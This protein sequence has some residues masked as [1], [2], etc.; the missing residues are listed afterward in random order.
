M[1]FEGTDAKMR[2]GVRIFFS[3]GAFVYDV[4]FLRRLRAYLNNVIKDKTK[5]ITEPMH[6]EVKGKSRRTGRVVSVSA[7]SKAQVSRRTEDPD[8]V[9]CGACENTKQYR[10]AI[11]ERFDPGVVHLDDPHPHRRTACNCWAYFS[12]DDLDIVQD[13]KKVTCGSCQRTTEYLKRKAATN[14]S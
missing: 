14:D 13:W 9:Y 7:C 10:A 11:G 6:F 2:R 1:E 8:K 12:N 3:G 5:H 4:A